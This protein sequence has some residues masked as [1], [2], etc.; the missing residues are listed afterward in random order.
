MIANLVQEDAK[1]APIHRRVSL[2]RRRGLCALEL[3]ALAL[4][5]TMTMALTL[6]V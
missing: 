1:P 6:T 3:F 2:A 5:G 4:V